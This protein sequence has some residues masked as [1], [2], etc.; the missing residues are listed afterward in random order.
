A[1][2]VLAVIYAWRPHR[3]LAVL[4]IAWTA[5]VWFSIVY[6]GEHYVVDALDGVV[7]VG[8]AVLMVERF[9]RLRA[10]RP[11]EA[12]KSIPNPAGLPCLL[13][14][15]DPCHMIRAILLAIAAAVLMPVV[16]PLPA[17]AA[18]SDMLSRV[19]HIVVI[20]QENWS[21]DS[22]YGKFPGA[23][24]LASA[25]DTVKQVDANGSPYTVLPQPLDTSVRPPAPDT[26]FPGNL[27]VQ[28][29][30]ASQY[31]QPDQKTGD[32]VHRFYQ[33]QLQIDGGKM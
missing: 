17:A 23:N 14:Q 33:E 31:V 30:D 28:P 32:L 26:R 27:P 22:L 8:V 21:F 20:Y 2:P 29:F 6:L 15:H 5:C 11:A 18:G 4:L 24:G 7:Y 10:A 3:K 16:V 9:S 19:G 13:R 1:Y 12:R 25:G